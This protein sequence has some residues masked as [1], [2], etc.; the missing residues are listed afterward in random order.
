MPK[1]KVVPTNP[2]PTRQEK[3]LARDMTQ[4]L[5]T[6]AI[7]VG[8]GP[9]QVQGAKMEPDGTIRLM[10]RQEIDAALVPRQTSPRPQDDPNLK[11]LG[12]KFDPR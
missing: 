10:T 1:I 3:R 4:N 5:I 12:I 9:D 11:A 8:F 7:D 2:Q 6:I